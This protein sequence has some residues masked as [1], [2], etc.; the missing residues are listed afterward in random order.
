MPAEVSSNMGRFDGMRYGSK[1]KGDTLLAEYMNTRGQRL[2]KEVRRRI[3]LGAY[4]LSAGYYDAYYNKAQMVREMLKEDFRNAFT[5]VDIILTPTAPSPAFK[6][7]ANTSDPIK[8]YL[9]DVFTV[10][11][12]LVG[13]PA[14]S[15]PVGMTSDQKPLPLA[16]QCMAAHGMEEVLF[17]IGQTIE[18]MNIA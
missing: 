18:K 17:T 16:I 15:V 3:M 5:Q 12:N 2:G 7:G 9:E 1:V 8:M 6:I 4:V 10:P 13:I 11:A 14:L